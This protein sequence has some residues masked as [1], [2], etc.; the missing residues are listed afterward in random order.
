[1]AFIRQAGPWNANWACFA[2]RKSVR[3]AGNYSGDVA[4]SGCGRPCRRLGTRI[5]IPG[6]HDARRWAELRES[7]AA[8]RYAAVRRAEATRVRHRHRLERQ[9]A[10]LEAL[11]I[12]PDRNRAMTR[13]RQQLEMA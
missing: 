9:L 10:A 2:C 7:I 5:R 8:S 3:R 1:M 11:T 13:L 4:C 12:D 6:S